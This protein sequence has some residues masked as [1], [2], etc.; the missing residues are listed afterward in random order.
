MMINGFCSERSF[1]LLRLDLAADQS[2]PPSPRT[3]AIACPRTIRYSRIAYIATH[4][5]RVWSYRGKTYMA[6]V[7]VIY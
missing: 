1:L 4:D 3:P 7:G 2:L 5:A 6:P